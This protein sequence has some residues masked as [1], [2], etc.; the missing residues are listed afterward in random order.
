MKR[1]LIVDDDPDVAEVFAQLVEILGYESNIADDVPRGLNLAKS[2][3]PVLVLCDLGLPGD[4]LNF[5][6]RCVLDE[7]LKSIKL[8]AVSGRSSPEDRKRALAAG[9]DDLLC[10][11]VDFATLQAVCELA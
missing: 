5:A 4:G 8:I 3:Q 9:F 11:P 10:K 1:I 7:N 2:W 6:R